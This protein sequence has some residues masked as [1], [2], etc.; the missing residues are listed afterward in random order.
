M[1]YRLKQAHRHTG[2]RWKGI[3]LG[4]KTQRTQTS[5][6][7][8]IKSTEVKLACALRGLARPFA[9]SPVP[10]TGRKRAKTFLEN[11]QIHRKTTNNYQNLKKTTKIALARSPV[12]KGGPVNTLC[13]IPV[14]NHL[15]KHGCL[16]F[17]PNASDHASAP[18]S[19]SKCGERLS[20]RKSS[21]VHAGQFWTI[22]RSGPRRHKY[23]KILET[24]AT[25]PW[26]C[27]KNSDVRLRAE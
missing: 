5:T 1:F 27:L 11:D 13:D 3:G 19:A 22:C 18:A 17:L 12:A 16:N 23:D 7:A 21:G 10:R 20:L 15:P 9:R 2:S 4:Q 8:T 26:P 25:Q 6:S 24:L 14:S